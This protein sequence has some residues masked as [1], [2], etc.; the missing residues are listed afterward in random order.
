MSVLG[1]HGGVPSF[2]A[3]TR[4]GE[5]GGRGE[6]EAYGR[7][8]EKGGLEAALAWCLDLVLLFSVLLLDWIDWYA[9][10]I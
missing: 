1:N 3:E 9:F 5:Q 7:C 2:L 8:V 6:D 4:R 10:S